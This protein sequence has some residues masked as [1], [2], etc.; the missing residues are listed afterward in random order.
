MTVQPAKILIVDDDEEIT[1]TISD[2]FNNS[3]L[4]IIPIATS[5]SRQV[6]PLLEEHEDIRLILSDFRMP[7]INGLELLLMVK[8][9]YPNVFFVIMTGYGTRELKKEW[10]KQG[11]VRYI[12]KPFDLPELAEL[13]RGTLKGPELGFGGRLESIQLPDIIQL[14]G[15]SGRSMALGLTADQGKGSL[16]FQKGEIVHAVCGD[17]V[18]AD[19]F[20]EIF[21]WSGGSFTLE[22]ASTDRAQT[23]AEPWQALLLEAARR[24]DEAEAGVEVLRAEEEMPPSRKDVRGNRAELVVGADVIEGV[25]STESALETVSPPKPARQKPDQIETIFA[26]PPPAEA[27]TAEAIVP[28]EKEPVTPPEPLPGLPVLDE[29]LISRALDR[30]VEH[31]LAAWPEGQDRILY[32][33]LPLK[34]LTS[35]I[36]RHIFHHIHQHLLQVIDTQDAM[37]DFS[38]QKIAGALQNLL[39]ALFE[40]YWITRD[41]YQRVLQDG[42]SFDLARSIDPAQAL[43]LFVHANAGGKV[44]KVTLFLRSM[45][46]CDL[47]GEHY[48]PLIEDIEKQGRQQIH[49]RKLEYLARAILYRQDEEDSCREVRG[50]LERILDIAAV[51]QDPPPVHIHPDVVIKMLES[52]GLVQV[53]DFIRA[54]GDAAPHAISVTELDQ[55]M[56]RYRSSTGQNDER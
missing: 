31:Y 50:A 29:E 13:I 16:Y 35:G 24:M 12:E 54:E 14:I 33:D 30:V 27:P 10:L 55:L 47:V 6:L 40:N 4:G 34:S 43:S 28:E 41:D 1:E 21:N 52:H 32:R 26:E 46:D 3:D 53:A 8:D 23:I 17:L 2:Y 15:M 25:K 19:A 22:P 49:P 38:S 45:I 5:D 36:R 56:E 51:A 11:A 42:V 48:R 39:Q 9:R 44:D 18:G 7:A 20:Y 37:F